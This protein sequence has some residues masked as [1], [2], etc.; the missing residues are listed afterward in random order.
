MISPGSEQSEVGNAIEIARLV[1]D[2]VWRNLEFEDSRVIT[3][4]SR[5]IEL[6]S[7]M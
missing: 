5:V 7:N 1:L 3:A 4:C 2:A 6:Y